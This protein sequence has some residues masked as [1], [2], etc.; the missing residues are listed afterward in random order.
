MADPTGTAGNIALDPLFCAGDNFNLG[1][2]SPCLPAGSGGCGLIGALGGSCGASPVP[3][4]DGAVPTAFRVDQ[5]FPN[6]FNPSTTIRFAL[7]EGGQTVVSIFDIKGRRVRTLVNDV[8]PAQ[9]HEV[10]WTGRDEDERQVAAGVY[11][12]MVT[13]GTHRAVGRMALV[14]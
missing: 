12:Y 2:A 8:L 3:G 6:P 9:V 1:A 5:D 4:D 7:P 13:S 10:T 14:K 11:F